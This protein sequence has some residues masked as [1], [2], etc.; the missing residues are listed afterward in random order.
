MGTHKSSVS[1]DSVSR[2]NN[3]KLHLRVKWS[4]TLWFWRLPVNNIASI[5]GGTS[6]TV[7]QP[8]DSVGVAYNKR[9][10]STLE[11]Y[12]CSVPQWFSK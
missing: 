12:K 1:T 5:K 11:T 3:K 7:V 6:I 4:E 10:N 2:R 8:S 9:L